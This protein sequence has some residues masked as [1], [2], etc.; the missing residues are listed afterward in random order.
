[1]DQGKNSPRT[2]EQVWRSYGTS[3][4]GMLKAQQ[5]YVREKRKTADQ[6]GS[7]QIVE[8]LYATARQ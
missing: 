3:T 8:A 5:E 7:T 2:E 4:P 1:M 6:R